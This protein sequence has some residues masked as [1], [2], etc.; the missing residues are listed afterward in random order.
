MLWPEAMSATSGAED[1]ET[2]EPSL[3][4]TDPRHS[5]KAKFRMRKYERALDK[6]TE[7]CM[8]P[9]KKTGV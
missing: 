7:Q 3:V 4:I 6:Q 9:S 5:E 8:T 1:L 2:T